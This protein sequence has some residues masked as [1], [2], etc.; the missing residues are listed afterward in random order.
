MDLQ[1]R[2]VK[3]LYFAGQLLGTSGYEEAAGLGLLAGINAVHRLHGK[4]EYIP[5]REDAYLGV[6]VDDVCG[7][8]HREPY[9]MFTSRADVSVGAAAAKLAPSWRRPA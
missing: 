5:T 4:E 7:R 9:R 6:L 8:E 1:S 2:E 3:G